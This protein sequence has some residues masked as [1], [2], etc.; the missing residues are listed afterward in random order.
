MRHEQ[1]VDI[2]GHTS[3]VVGE[4][5]RC[6]ADDEHIGDHASAHQAIAE[7]SERPFELRSVK[8]DVPGFSH[9]ASRSAAARY[10]PCLRKAAGA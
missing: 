10:T 8:Q 6:S 4:S 2:A 9:A 1:R 3:G 5:H 7:V